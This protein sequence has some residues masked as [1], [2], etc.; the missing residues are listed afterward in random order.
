MIGAR[1][2]RVRHQSDQGFAV[3]L[4][5]GLVATVFQAVIVNR[6]LFAIYPATAP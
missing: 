4:A 5:L 3:T 2:L 6:L 1:A